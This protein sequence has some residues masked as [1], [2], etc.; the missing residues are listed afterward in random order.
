M[1][2]PSS[3]PLFTTS[4]V[5]WSGSA[6]SF[7]C[8]LIALVSLFS[9]CNSRSH[10]SQSQDAAKGS[11]ENHTY[12][13]KIEPDD[14]QWIR[15]AKDYASTRYSSLDQINTENIKDLKVAFTFSTGT[16]RGHEAAPL[17]VNNTMYI[18]TPWPNLLYALDLTQPGAPMKWKYDPRPAAAAKGVA[19]CDWVNRGASYDGG[20]IYFNTLDG[21]N[22][23]VD[24]NTGQ[25][26]YK[27]QLADITKGESITMAPL[28]AKGKVFVGVSGGEFGIHG[29]LKAVDAKTG[30]I[31]WT[32]YDLGPDHDVLIGPRFKP[33]YS[34]Y[35]GQD[36]GVKSSPPDG[37]K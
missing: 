4:Q 21:Y 17:V 24:A 14:G 28:V 10:T 9:A 25:Q 29:W 37:W 36:L 7:I 5:K 13:G 11:F 18:V 35:K 34:Q 2:H 15:P 1:M 6:G 32:A 31:A 19:C 16:D 27:T 33:F 12:Q 30:K 8:L 20:K 23:A 22:I 3:G 26:I